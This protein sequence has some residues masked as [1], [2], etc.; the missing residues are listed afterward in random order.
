M[1]TFE[2]LNLTKQLQYAID[3]LGFTAPT[4]VQEQAFSTICAGKD[5]VGIAQTGTGKTF[6]YLLPMLRDLKFSKQLNPRILILVP[7]RELVMQIVEEAEKI[8]KYMNVRT[9]GVYGGV[10]INTQRQTLAQTLF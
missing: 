4:P 5:M 2:E 3:D 7:T 1:S 6:A 9:L 8:T 10:N